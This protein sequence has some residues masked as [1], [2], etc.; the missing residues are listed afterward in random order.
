MLLRT[1]LCLLLNNYFSKIYYQLT[2]GS[3]LGRSQSRY[4]QQHAIAPQPLNTSSCVAPDD[5]GDFDRPSIDYCHYAGIFFSS[6]FRAAYGI[7]LLVSYFSF[8]FNKLTHIVLKQIRLKFHQKSITKYMA[9]IIVHVKQY[10]GGY[11][12]SKACETGTK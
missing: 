11:A 4:L 8:R 12:L 1:H 10:C 6:V 2:N 5:M 7:I 9:M 3:C